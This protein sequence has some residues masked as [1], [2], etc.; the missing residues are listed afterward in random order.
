MR[1]RQ[2]KRCLNRVNGVSSTEP[3]CCRRGTSPPHPLFP[4]PWTKDV[5]LGETPPPS[6]N[7]G[8]A[9]VTFISRSYAPNIFEAIS[10]T[11]LEYPEGIHFNAVIDIQTDRHTNDFSWQL[12]ILIYSADVDTY[13]RVMQLCKHAWWLLYRINVS[14]YICDDWYWVQQ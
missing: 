6:C 9:P 1:I 4:T 11:K 12:S 10:C 7:T 5:Y 14:C 2:K 8:Y 3:S 13:T